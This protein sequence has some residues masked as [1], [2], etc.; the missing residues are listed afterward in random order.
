MLSL[1]EVIVLVWFF[2]FMSDF[3]EKE[4]TGVER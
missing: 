1:K 4:S 3:V 2:K